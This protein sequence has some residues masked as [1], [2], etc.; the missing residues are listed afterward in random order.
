ML[1]SPMARRIEHFARIARPLLTMEA[2]RMEH[3]DDG[4]HALEGR[5]RARGTFYAA[6]VASLSDG[7]IPVQ[8]R[9]PRG[10]TNGGAAGSSDVDAV[11]LVKKIERIR[12]SEDQFSER[13]KKLLQDEAELAAIRTRDAAGELRDLRW[14]SERTGDKHL[15]DR[16]R[17]AAYRDKDNIA[18]PTRGRRGTYILLKPSEVCDYLNDP[19]LKRDIMD[20]LAQ[21]SRPT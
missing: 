21:E 1:L 12:Q 4:A 10:G 13:V 2:R 14:F 11:D 17:Q 19:V 9:H 5:V 16:L 6:E 15:A 3:F 8:S 20:A 18:F 7:S